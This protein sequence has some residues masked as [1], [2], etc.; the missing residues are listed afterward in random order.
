ML[1]KLTVSAVGLMLLFFV[2]GC[3]ESAPN[4][5]KISKE[6]RMVMDVHSFS[7]PW[8]VRV[9]H[10]HLILKADFSIKMLQGAA[11]LSLER[12][13]GKDT[14]FL[15]SKDLAISSVM[16]ALNGQPLKW[17]F[18]PEDSIL[19]KGIRIALA[20]KTKEVTVYY[21]T[22]PKA[23]AIQWLEP[24]QTA[25]GQ[26]PFLFTQ[27]EAILTRSWIPLQD[28][29]EVRI[30]YSADIECPPQ[31]MAV[32]SAENDTVKDPK[33]KYRFSM[34][35][36]VSPYLI[37]LAIGDLQFKPLG[38]RTGVFAEPAT[39]QSAVYEFA[40]TEKM[41]D[42]AEKLYGP[43]AWDR[44]D[45]LVLPPSFPFGGMENPRLTFA[46]P[47]ILAGDRSLTSLIAHEL[48]HSWSGNLVTN[49]TWNDFWLNE[50]FTVY[51]ERR[52][53]ELLYGKDYS[54]M[55]ACL[56]YS[57]LNATMDEMGRDSAD[58]QLKLDLKGRNP[59]DGMNDI[60]YEKGYFML[61]TMED[62]MGR[63]A[64]D[65]YL[66]SYFDNFK[67]TTLNTESWLEYTEKNWPEKAAKP[68]SSLNLKE[69][70]YKPNLPANCPK[71]VSER[72][73][74]VDKA[75]EMWIT[76]HKTAD[77][78]TKGWTTH[79]YLRFIEKIAPGVNV[80]N[81]KD[82]DEAFKF[83]QTG[84]SE[85]AAVWFVAAAKHNYKP[86]FEPMEKFLI[87][88]GRRKFILPIYKTLNANPLQ[89][90]RATE[91]YKKARTGYH[92]V[93]RNTLDA[94]LGIS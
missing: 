72:F 57:D 61:R 93:A 3:K 70:I 16:D 91:I 78:S 77:L 36:P 26:E 81:M 6:T 74:N 92:F 65:A 80:E 4:N 48:A 79:E 49:A 43:Y 22:S 84:N 45:I 1:P 34:Q 60:A 18:M 32:M 9:T 89:K 90:E 28:S 13:P 86:A 58:T 71:P 44:Y 52:I 40:E 51:F 87:K 5:A 66:T 17:S 68:F 85:I 35:Q 88:T 14:L 67:F 23:E 46:T 69:W 41:V 11:I 24:G 19:G 30:T 38:S 47:T 59:D 37:A 39:L 10:L 27:G 42:A 8:E 64:F 55:L 83:S 75:A 76:T 62:A 12:Q 2:S 63:E 20:E 29:P 21:S 31:L 33:G 56:G 25:G 94:L 53:M 50:G 73:A 15:D 54:D 82:L 7:R